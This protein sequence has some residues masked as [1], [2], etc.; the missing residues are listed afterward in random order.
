MNEVTTHTIFCTKYHC[1]KIL[2]KDVVES[3]L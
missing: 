1:R 2:H 3:L